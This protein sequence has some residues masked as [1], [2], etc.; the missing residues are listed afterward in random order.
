MASGCNPIGKPPILRAVLISG[1]KK[2]N[3][4]MEESAYAIFHHVRQRV[5]KKC[6]HQIIRWMSIETTKAPDALMTA[7]AFRPAVQLR[8]SPEPNNRPKTTASGEIKASAQ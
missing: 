4:E 2:L 1:K 5:L 3:L 7:T 6:L 8:V